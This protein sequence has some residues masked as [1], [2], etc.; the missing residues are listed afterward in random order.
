MLKKLLA[1]RCV[2]D[3]SRGYGHFSRCL[4]IANYFS[5]RDYELLFLINNDIL[6]KN[7]LGEAID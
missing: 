2:A 7:E 6:M 1:I 3:H 5:K 4:A